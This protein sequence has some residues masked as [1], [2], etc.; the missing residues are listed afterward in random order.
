MHE[1][2]LVANLSGDIR[3]ETLHGR[4]HLVAPLTLIV[5]GVLT[6]S[7]GPLLYP[8]TEVER[9]PAIW[10]GVPLTVYHPK[11]NGQSVSAKDPDILNT[12]GIGVLLRARI[13]NGKLKAE[14]WFDIDS[15]RRIDDRIYEALTQNKPMELSTGLGVDREPEQGEFNGR[16]YEA[17]AK[18]YRPDHVAILPDQLGACS[19]ADGCG[20]LI[21]K[22]SE[23]MDKE[24][25]ELIS[26]LVSNCECWNEDDAEV[27][28]NF[29]PEKLEALAVSAK[30]AKQEAT[31]ANAAKAGFKDD[32]VELTFNE[33]S[34]EWSHEVLVPVVEN[35]EA[36]ATP[37]ADEWMKTAPPAIQS[38]VKN[39]MVI[40]QR[41]KAEIVATLLA[42]VGEETKLGLDQLLMSKELDELRQLAVLAPAQNEPSYF[43]AAGPIGN[44]KADD[45]LLPIPRMNYA[46]E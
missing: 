2:K 15:T 9:E 39:A 37:T 31:V 46:T 3:R 24:K 17:I 43:G 20:V 29:S 12:Q 21:N 10:N 36:E 14:G 28:A 27:L 38:A 35:E 22:E 8:A 33:E 16:P 40:E 23:K 45:D 13:S 5:P 6:G 26:S 34:L 7:M 25:R 42:N 44:Q 11:T 19:I 4:E 1:V 30:S 18:N 32:Q 41:E